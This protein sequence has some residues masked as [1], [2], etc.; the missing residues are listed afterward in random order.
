MMLGSL[1]AINSVVFIPNDGLVAFHYSSYGTFCVHLK[2]SINLQWFYPLQKLDSLSTVVGWRKAKFSKW[3]NPFFCEF[4][5]NIYIYI[6]CIKN[7]LYFEEACCYH[8]LVSRKQKNNINKLNK[9][10]QINWQ[11]NMI[12]VIVKLLL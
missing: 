4:L 2:S 9:T 11:I 10:R 5:C 8:F 1:I 7:Q 6:Y 3:G 12:W